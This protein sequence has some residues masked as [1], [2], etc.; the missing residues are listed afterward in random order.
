MVKIRL[1]IETMTWTIP[2]T[3]EARHDF[4]FDCKWT[5]LH[6]V[7]RATKEVVAMYTREEVIRMMSR[8]GREK[9]KSRSGIIVS[10]HPTMV[11]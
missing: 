6:I 9:K 7:H 2:E 10:V 3:S 5:E 11:A 4:L 1:T 8:P